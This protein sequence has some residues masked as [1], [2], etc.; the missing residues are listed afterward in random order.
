MSVRSLSQSTTP[1]TCTH[2]PASLRSPSVSADA[3]MV[4]SY[5]LHQKIIDQ[6]I[7]LD[8]KAEVATFNILPSAF[9]WDFFWGFS[10]AFLWGFLGVY[11]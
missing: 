3:F 2:L 10:G 11:L 5:T 4:T 9:F 6:A 7:A 8:A 1:H